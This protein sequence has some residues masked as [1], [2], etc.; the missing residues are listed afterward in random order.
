MQYSLQVTMAHAA[1]DDKI[2]VKREC[3]ASGTGNKIC[4]TIT[5]GLTCAAGAKD[6]AWCVGS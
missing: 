1:N 5:N 3:I 4:Q 2:T 6:T